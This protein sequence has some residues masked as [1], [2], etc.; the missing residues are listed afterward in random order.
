MLM[1]DAIFIKPGHVA[2]EDVAKPE[3]QAPDDVILHIV[4]TCVCG[5]DLWDY[6]G[7]DKVPEHSQNGGHEAIGVV[8]AVGSAITTVTPGDF[9]IA[10]FTHGCGHCAACRAGFDAN[11][12]SYRDNFSEGAQAEYMRYQ[13]GEWALV[14]IPGQ[15][16]DYSEDM[17]KSLL[18][19]ADVMA[20]GYHAARMATVG[21]GDT[22]VVVGDGAVGL[23]GVIA[24]QMR[25]AKRIIAMSRHEDRQKLAVE[26]GATDIVPERGDDGV[27]KVMA[28]TNGVG[29]DAV[30]ECVGTEQAVDTALKVGRPGARVG[31]VGIPH[32]SAMDLKPVF[33]RNITVTGGIAS[34]TTYDKEFLLKAVLDGTIHPGKVF[35]KSFKLDE[36]EAAY[37]AMD[38]REAIKSLVVTD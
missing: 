37:Q 18:S 29:A 8:E 13:H 10:P 12:L 38:K 3:V 28:L 9:V 34:V 15:P 35:T 20:T 6:R 33:S 23:C 14:K 5:S 1:K 21:T 4:R 36:I 26:F 16:S 27:A 25:G 7:L 2:I 30:L 11:C 24:A 32:N 17:L 31:R 22:V 19:L